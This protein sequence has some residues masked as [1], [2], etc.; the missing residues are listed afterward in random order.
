MFL[1]NTCNN[2]NHFMVATTPLTLG[3]RK[4]NPGRKR[5]PL[6]WSAWKVLPCWVPGS[7]GEFFDFDLAPNLYQF[8]RIQMDSSL[9]KY[10][11]ASWEILRKVT[12]TTLR[13]CLLI[14]LDCRIRLHPL[15]LLPLRTH[16]VGLN[17]DQ[18]VKAIDYVITMFKIVLE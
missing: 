18:P 7:N 3:G 13:P 8:K 12:S 1:L 9:W 4:W 11:V 17:F 16:H 14:Q 10:F 2:F 15:R 6:S 5:R